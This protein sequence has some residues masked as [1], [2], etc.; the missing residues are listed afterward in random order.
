M[1]SEYVR[2]V[3]LTKMCTKKKPTRKQLE[4]YIQNAVSSIMTEIIP[5]HLSKN[6]QQH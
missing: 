5:C 1:L 3:V 4:V 6:D 2:E